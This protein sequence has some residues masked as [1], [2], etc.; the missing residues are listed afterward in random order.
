VKN[1]IIVLTIFISG[2]S[3]QPIV[4]IPMDNSK[5]P[6]IYGYG[7]VDCGRIKHIC[8]MNKNRGVPNSNQEYLEWKTKDGTTMC[9][10][11]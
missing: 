6:I 1:I 3:I 7:A 11:K 2:C 4:T 10:C 9:S 8:A 5:E